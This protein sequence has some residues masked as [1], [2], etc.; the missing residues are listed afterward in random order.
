SVYFISDRNGN[1]DFYQKNI[2]GTGLKRITDSPASEMEFS[3]SPDGTHVL[4]TSGDM[5]AADIYIMKTDGTGIKRI[6]DNHSRETFLSWSPN[7]KTIS[8]VSDIDGDLEV[9][10]I[11]ME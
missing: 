7:G 2:D 3:L 10:T 8:F 9:Y 5:S 1:Y 6:T 4:Y 11:P